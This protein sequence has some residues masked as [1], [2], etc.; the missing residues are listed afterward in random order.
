[1]YST[2]TPAV[3]ITFSNPSSFQAVKEGNRMILFDGWCGRQFWYS[4]TEYVSVDIDDSLIPT[5][6]I[7]LRCSQ[8]PFY[9][10]RRGWNALPLVS[11]DF[12]TSISFST[13]ML[14]FVAVNT[15][16]EFISNPYSVNCPHTKIMPLRYRQ[17]SGKIFMLSHKK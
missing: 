15:T 9:T 1:M 11:W 12:N 17:Q 14:W 3:N 2:P 13:D 8:L 7:H 4:V 5:N 16:Q 10:E 6:G